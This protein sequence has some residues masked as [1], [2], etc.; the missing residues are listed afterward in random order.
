MDSKIKLKLSE[1][2]NSDKELRDLAK[3]LDVHIDDIV[4]IQSVDRLP[5]RGTFII[6]LRRDAGVGHWVCVCDGMYF[7]SYGIGAPTKLKV[8]SYNKIQLQSATA[9]Y[10]GI[11]C[12]LFLYSKQK[13][14]PDL[15]TGFTDLNVDI[16]LSH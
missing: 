10:C 13:N 6:L 4:D 1:G 7:D 2:V 5:S 16:T 8:K 14:R 11:Y 3:L 9:N 12:I 15:M